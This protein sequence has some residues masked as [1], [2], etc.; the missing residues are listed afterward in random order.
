MWEPEQLAPLSLMLLY[1][2][3]CYVIYGQETKSILAA[4]RARCCLLKRT[5]CRSEIFMCVNITPRSS[6]EWTSQHLTT[7]SDPTAP[8]QT[9]QAAV[10]MVNVQ[11]HAGTTGKR[12]WTSME[13]LEGLQEK[14][15]STLSH[16]TSGTT[17]DQSGDVCPQSSIFWGKGLKSPGQSP[18][19]NLMLMWD[20]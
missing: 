16:K 9:L 14:T 3:C 11:V 15:S 4:L 12:N 7:T 1:S 20:L 18:D 6:Q 19:F 5:V 13:R 17:W 2:L 10:S 8:S